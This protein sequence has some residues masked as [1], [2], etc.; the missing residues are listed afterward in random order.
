MPKKPRP[1]LS[2]HEKA[3]IR[4]IAL[5]HG[6]KLG[7][8]VHAGW[9]EGGEKPLVIKAITLNDTIELRPKG[10]RLGKCWFRTAGDFT[11]FDADRNAWRLA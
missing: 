7:D 4:R 5:E 10:G 11:D 3:E 9:H 1:E 6:P 2:E 8:R